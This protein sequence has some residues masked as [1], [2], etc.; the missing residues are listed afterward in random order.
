MY[1]FDQNKYIIITKSPYILQI[2][3]HKIHHVDQIDYHTAISAFHQ[4]IDPSVQVT[5]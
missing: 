4:V 3:S 1:K 5:V 2:S